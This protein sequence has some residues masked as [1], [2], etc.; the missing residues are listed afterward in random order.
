MFCMVYLS[1]HKLKVCLFPLLARVQQSPV[2]EFIQKSPLPLTPIGTTPSTGSAQL[3][4]GG[5]PSTDSAESRPSQLLVANALAPRTTV[6]I[7]AARRGSVLDAAAAPGAQGRRG[8]VSVNAAGRRGSVSGGPAA[9]DGVGSRRSSVSV[10]GGNVSRR[11][12][13][14]GHQGIARLPSNDSHLAQRSAYRK[15][16]ATIRQNWIA[17]VQMSKSRNEKKHAS[18]E[19]PSTSSGD[20]QPSTPG[21]SPL[22]DLESNST[23]SIGLTTGLLSS[24]SSSIKRRVPRQ[25]SIFQGGTFTKL[26][27]SSP[28]IV[29]M[30]SVEHE[31]EQQQKHVDT[32]L[33]SEEEL[34][35]KQMEQRRLKILQYARSRIG[36][37]QPTSTSTSTVSSLEGLEGSGGGSG[38]TNKPGRKLAGKIANTRP[39]LTRRITTPNLLEVGDANQSPPSASRDNVVAP[40]QAVSALQRGGSGRVSSPEAFFGR[41]KS[42]RKAGGMAQVT[43]DDLSIELTALAKGDDCSD[44]NSDDDD[45]DDSDDSDAE[46]NVRS[47]HV[48][49]QHKKKGS[50]LSSKSRAAPKLSSKAL[51]LPISVAGSPAFVSL[52][53]PVILADPGAKDPIASIIEADI[54]LANDRIRTLTVS[55]GAA[56]GGNT[57][58]SISTSSSGS[59]TDT[60]T[61]IHSL[62]DEDD[63]GPQQ[64]QQQQHGGY[65]LHPSVTVTAHD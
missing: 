32:I 58:S 36:L 26:M 28:V 63:V 42:M 9:K 30:D 55:P 1:R 34:A 44:S 13:V 43:A 61:K 65:H 15:D 12:S 54:A 51:S 35:S 33:A 37:D 47:A 53:S 3:S 49:K 23:S 57:E 52:A 46:V 62:Q 22:G 24:S 38:G 45:D 56:G 20:D 2:N 4:L 59:T 8:S 27:G 60:D 10:A 31:G 17:S 19:Q 25:G 21:D 16:P 7:S 41:K 11:A 48:R 18:D 5:T 14:S 64:Q 29:P 39:P 50:S 40:S 6:E